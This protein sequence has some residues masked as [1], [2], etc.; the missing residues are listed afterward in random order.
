[1]RFL[2]FGATG[3]T[4]QQ[5]V[6]QALDRGDEVTAFVRTPSKMSLAHPRLRKL[7]G[8]ITD[9]ESIRRAVPGH[10]AVLSA[11]GTKSFK[12]TTVLSDAL[13]EIIAAMQTAN[14]KRLIWQSSMGVGETRGQLG[15]L[16]TRV[17]VPLLLRHVFE[18]KERQEAILRASPLEEWVIVQP[19]ALTNGPLTKKYRAGRDVCRDRKLPRISRADVAH[20]MLI[21]AARPAHARQYVT[22]CY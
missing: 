12:A 15:P 9:A 1:M 21:E 11:L 16:Y 22:L 18:D 19:A 13:N 2:I 4:G 17:L 6:S 14:M 7:Q 8:D 3:G 10:T 5:L 20:F